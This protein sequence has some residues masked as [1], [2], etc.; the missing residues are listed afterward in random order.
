MKRNEKQVAIKLVE[1]L[2]G[3]EERKIKEVAKALIGTLAEHRELHRVRKIIDAMDWAWTKKYGA[4][5]IKIRTSFPITDALRKKILSLVP[6][7]ELNESV[8]P[9]LIAGAKIQIGEKI[10]DNTIKTKLD[11]L[12]A[13]LCN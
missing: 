9:K 6:G 7:V 5:V 1:C 12:R 13:S 10:F 4:S 2:E 11:K 8:D 3:A